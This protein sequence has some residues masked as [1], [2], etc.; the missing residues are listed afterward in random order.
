MYEVSKCAPRE[1]LI[2]LDHAFQHFFR[3]GKAFLLFLFFHDELEHSLLLKPH[4]AESILEEASQAQLLMKALQWLI[5]TEELSFLS[6]AVVLRVHASA[7]I[8]HLIVVVIL[9]IPPV[10]IMPVIAAPTIAA[11]MMVAATI[12]APMMVTPTMVTTPMTS[13]PRSSYQG[14]FL[15]IQLYG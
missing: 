14:E 13:T 11:P 2:D 7:T 4:L 10:P 9:A 8:P 3:S 6:A 5:T 12:A 1:V 15:L